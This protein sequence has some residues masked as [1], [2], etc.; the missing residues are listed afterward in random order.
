[1][2][3]LPFNN[4]TPEWLL[5]P[6][7]YYTYIRLLFEKVRWDYGGLSSYF[8]KNYLAEFIEPN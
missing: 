4:K 8:V 3:P 5:E 7:D 6:Y 1:M 2:L